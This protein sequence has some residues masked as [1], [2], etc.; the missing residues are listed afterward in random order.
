MYMYIVLCIH[1]CV[2][3]YVYIYTHTYKYTW[4]YPCIKFRQRRKVLPHYSDTDRRYYL[5]FFTT[6]TPN[7]SPLPKIPMRTVLPHFHHKQVRYLQ[8]CFLIRWKVL[9]HYRQ[10]SQQRRTVLLPFCHIPQVAKRRIHPP[11]G[12]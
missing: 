7:H 8:R 9:P 5:F 12:P 2:C 11:E 6:P 10:K 4:T 3:V 1:I